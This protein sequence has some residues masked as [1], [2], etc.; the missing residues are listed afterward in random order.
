MLRPRAGRALRRAWRSASSHRRRRVC[1]GQ[2]SAKDRVGHASQRTDHWTLM[3]ATA[4]RREVA[5]PS[6]R[7]ATIDKTL[8]A[9]PDEPRLLAIAADEVPR[10]ARWGR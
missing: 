6:A 2:R 4:L 1:G 8:S 7:V 10:G 3:D 9:C 5:T